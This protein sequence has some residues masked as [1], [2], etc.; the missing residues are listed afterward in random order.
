MLNVI[1]ED[2]HGFVYAR[3][4]FD[5]D[6]YMVDVELSEFDIEWCVNG[7]ESDESSEEIEYF[8]SEYFALGV[9]VINS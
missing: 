1:I 9:Y 7:S 3:D 8:D 6:E 5:G 2:M 4:H